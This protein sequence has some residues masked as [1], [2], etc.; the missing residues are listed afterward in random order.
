MHF[1]C[2]EHELDFL[3]LI[4]NLI[5]STE[6]FDKKITLI[7]KKLNF[8]NQLIEL[9]K[10]YLK[11]DLQLKAQDDKYHLERRKLF[12]DSKSRNNVD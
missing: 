5:E 2:K 8:I 12:E 1:E 11:T 7:D 10:E 3:E 6:E 4:D 9:E